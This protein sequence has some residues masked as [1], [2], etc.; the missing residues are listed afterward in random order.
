MQ[1]RTCD[2][3]Q[4]ELSVEEKAF[5]AGLPAQQGSLG[6][7]L[8]DLHANGPAVDGMRNGFLG[9][10]MP[11]DE[12]LAAYGIARDAVLSI[13]GNGTKT[14]YVLGASDPEMREI[15]VLLEKH[16][17]STDVVLYATCEDRPVNPGNAY[18]ADSIPGE[19]QQVV[20]IE[21]DPVPPPTA[22]NFIRVDHHR[23]GDPGYG[24][25]PAEFWSASAIGQLFNLLFGSSQQMVDMYYHPTHEQLV[26]AAMDH[27]PA[28][29]IQGKC[30]G[31]TAEEILERK[32]QE[33]SLQTKRGK[34]EI[35]QIVNWAR[36]RLSASPVISLGEQAVIDFRS[37]NLGSDYTYLAAVQTAALRDGQTVLLCHQDQNGREKWSISGHATPQTI[38]IFKEEWADAQGLNDVYG[39]P[40]RGFAGGYPHDPNTIHP[41]LN[42][43]NVPKENAEHTKQV[44]SE[45]NIPFVSYEAPDSYS[46]YTVYVPIPAEV[47]EQVEPLLTPSGN[48]L[49]PALVYDAQVPGVITD[50]DEALRFLKGLAQNRDEALRSFTQSNK[51]EQEG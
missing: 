28:A 8:C 2:V 35:E 33:I 39:V 16:H 18:R 17:M 51:T 48:I 4:R 14:L 21:C 22:R 6:E 46:I 31:V 9:W 47:V 12:T 3:C 20:L 1:T 40:E 5:Y 10:R 19:W 43:F 45:A 7:V 15:E 36:I 23:P 42:S 25:P 50:S 38:R 30:P 32:V 13:L 34:K 27:R 41:K 11:S 49:E 26:L 29:A 37:Y 24:K 44:L